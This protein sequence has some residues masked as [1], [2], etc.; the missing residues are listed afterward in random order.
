MHAYAETYKNAPRIIFLFTTQ[1]SIDDEGYKNASVHYKDRFT[2]CMKI[3]VNS[4]K[5]KNGKN[6]DTRNA[7]AYKHKKW[8]IR[9]VVLYV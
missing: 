4:V 9:R 8:G 7:N 5:Q 2:E 1:I 3:I 6:R